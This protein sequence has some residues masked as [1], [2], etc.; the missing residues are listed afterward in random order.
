MSANY[1]MFTAQ[2]WKNW[3]VIYSIHVLSGILPSNHLKV[4][5]HFVE[6]CKIL[7]QP[8]IKKEVLQADECLLQ[9]C[10][11][12]QTIFGK[13]VVTPNMHLSCHLKDSIF[14]YGP[15]YSFWLFSFER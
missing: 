4:W 11:A 12:F 9:F 5:I 2:E 14:D 13:L 3:T 6:A 15:V 8:V 7:C 1:G 10:K